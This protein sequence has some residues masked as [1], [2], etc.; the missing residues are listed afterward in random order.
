[1]NVDLTNHLGSLE[2]IDIGD[3]EVESTLLKVVASL[4]RRDWNDLV[5]QTTSFYLTKIY[6]HRKYW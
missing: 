2:I 6:Q 5:D 3:S 1:M 4:F